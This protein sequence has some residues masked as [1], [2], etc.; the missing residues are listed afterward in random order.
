[1]TAILKVL[2]PVLVV[3]AIAAVYFVP[4]ETSHYIFVSAILLLLSF[5]WLLMRRSN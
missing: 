4:E 5:A 2:I 1:V 3:V